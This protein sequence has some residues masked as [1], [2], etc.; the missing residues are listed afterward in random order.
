MAVHVLTDA[1]LWLNKYD[2]SGDH[3]ALSLGYAADAQDFT[4]FGQTTR[5]RKG[6][7]RSVS[8]SGNG[9]WS[10]GTGLVDDVLFGNVGVSDSPV[11]IALQGGAVGDPAYL[12]R[13]YQGSY[14]ASGA[15]GEP[16]E[17]QVQAE[18]S[19]GEGL[20][21]G[22]VLEN[23][24]KTSTG[25]GTK[26]LAGAATA[27]QSVYAALHVITVSGTNPT[28]DVVVESD[29]NASAGG[30]TSRITFAQATAAT[31]EWQSAAGAI[32]DTYWRVSYTVGGT[33]P[34]FAFVV[35]LGII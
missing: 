6:G 8:L 11:S 22:F 33:N 2:L 26:I 19:R 10:G 5:V 27:T 16:F 24:T 30:E 31:S 17:F 4:A 35:T 15:V 34:S 20:V 13:A 7:L 29:A 25:A 28:L 21:K 3:S 32:T 23:A 12:F 1:K 14:S 18:A 9:F